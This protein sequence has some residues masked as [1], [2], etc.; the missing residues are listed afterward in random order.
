VRRALLL[1]ALVAGAAVAADSVERTRAWPV[2][3]TG[4]W[5]SD[6]GGRVYLLSALGIQPYDARASNWGM[7]VVHGEMVVVRRA[8]AVVRVLA[9]PRRNAWWDRYTVGAAGELIADTGHLTPAGDDL[10]DVQHVETL[11]RPP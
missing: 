9:N 8:G 2:E 10:V 5:A 6:D 3:L 4:E 1:L 7:L 11:I